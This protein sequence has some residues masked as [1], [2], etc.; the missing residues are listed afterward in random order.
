MV[1]TCVL[2]FLLV[3]NTSV[4]GWLTWYASTHHDPSTTPGASDSNEIGHQTDSTR[5]IPAEL[6]ILRLLNVSGATPG[7]SEV[8]GPSAHL[9]AYKFRP[10]YNNVLVP[11]PGAI[12]AALTAPAG[13]TLLFVYRQPR[14]TLG[15]LLSIHSPGRVT[16]W[17]QLTSN[18]RTGQLVLHYRVTSDTKLHQ[19]SW[20]LQQQQPVPVQQSARSSCIP[21]AETRKGNGWAH[22][23]LVFNASLST[24][25]LYLDCQVEKPQP[26]AGNTGTGT[27]GLHIPQ[28]SL[29]YF[30]QEPGFKKKFLGSMQVA[31]I[32]SHPVSR[33][34]IGWCCKPLP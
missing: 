20:A 13:F 17:F 29:V 2:L 22:L 28:D 24:L 6:D 23:A 4:S 25:T 12:A 11:D 31:K 5:S 8:L 27:V 14:K 1:V 32:K 30:R 18:L 10:G 3:S 16:P 26:I 34:D 19:N 7:V 33:K 9:P 15:T 21:A